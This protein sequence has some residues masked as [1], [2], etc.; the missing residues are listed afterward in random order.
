MAH[1]KRDPGD[2]IVSG[3]Q[4]VT[5]DFSR[6]NGFIAGCGQA[7]LL[8][9][10]GIYHKEPVT[11]Q[12]VTNLILESVRAGKTVGG[13]ASSGESSP[14]TLDWLASVH[15]LQL[16]DTD[17]HLALQQAGTRPITLG[18]ANAGYGFGGDDTG[19][20]GHY[21]EIVEVKRP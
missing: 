9:A 15:G 11:W 13:K 19:V 20:F 14:A 16:Q 10:L 21:I 5:E 6:V 1:Y 18:V 3:S 8:V 7:A 4:A 12:E 17:W 2:V